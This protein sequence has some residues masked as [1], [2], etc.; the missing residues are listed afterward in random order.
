MKLQVAALRALVRRVVPETVRAG[1]RERHKI[2]GIE[3]IVHQPVNGHSPSTD[4]E[5]SSA[6][7]TA[8]TIETA[9]RAADA[10]RAAG[11]EALVRTGQQPG[12]TAKVPVV[13]VHVLAGVTLAEHALNRIMAEF[14]QRT[15]LELCY[16]DGA[17]VNGQAVI[18]PGHSP[19]RLAEQMYLGPM[20]AFRRSRRDAA[21]TSDWDAAVEKARAAAT[22]AHIPERLYTTIE[23]RA[24]PSRPEPR[25]AM[26]P[27]PKQPLVSIVIPTRG[28]RRTV[29]GQEVVLVEQAIESILSRSSYAAIELVVVTTPGTPRE[30]R[31]C[32]E[33]LIDGHGA[34]PRFVHDD[35]P[36]NFSNV[37]NVG[38]VATRGEVLIFLNDDTEVISEQ[39]I[40]W[41]VGHA[42]RPEV[43]AVGAKLLYE[44]GTIQHAGIWSRGGHPTHRYEGHPDNGGYRGALTVAQNCLAVTGACL[45]VERSKFQAV[46]GFSPIFPNSYNDVDLCLKLLDRGWRT[47]VEPRA[48]LHHYEA[49]TRDPSIDHG[50]MAAL[51]DRWRWRLNNDPF[52]NPTHDAALSEE[53]PL[54]AKANMMSEVSDWQPAQ[55]WPLPA[56]TDV[57]AIGPS[58]TEGTVWATCG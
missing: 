29:R 39:C 12:C 15:D 9:R 13:E 10:C 21:P 47:V 23:G 40:E 17:G 18:L 34:V 6:D 44:D 19:D 3:V 43:G 27:E 35:R 22:A 24:I 55:Y 41:L 33:A 5:S 48:R 14:N 11:V 30:L 2:A 26:I 54:S 57:A 56:M 42:L 53:L 50:D 58:V 16:S 20:L 31:G 28:R 36:F 45:T 8:L 25:I 7:S 38:A 52:D 32:L 37:C 46:G 51:H 49:S 1:I 4:A